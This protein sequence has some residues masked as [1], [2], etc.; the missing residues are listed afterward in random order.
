MFRRCGSP[1]GVVGGRREPDPPSD[2][3]T[4]VRD[5]SRPPWMSCP[6]RCRPSATR[7]APTCARSWPQGSS[8]ASPASPTAGLAVRRRATA[9]SAGTLPRGQT[10]DGAPARTAR[11]PVVGGRARLSGP[12]PG[13]DVAGARVGRRGVPPREP[14]ARPDS[15]SQR[16]DGDRLRAAR[17]RLGALEREARTWSRAERLLLDIARGLFADEPR[18]PVAEV[19][20]ALDPDQRARV[21]AAIALAAGDARVVGSPARASRSRPSGQTYAALDAFLA[22]WDTGAR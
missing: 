9:S 22:P 12:G 17:H 15:R 1:G 21:L 3:A 5:S 19:A 11:S 2:R 6:R 20:R 4:S 13:V 8:P 16:P 18:G 14:L 10:P 7:C